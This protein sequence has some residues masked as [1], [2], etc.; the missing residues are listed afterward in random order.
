MIEMI[1]KK[2]LG[3]PAVVATSVRKSTWKERNMSRIN[4]AYDHT[5][6][7]YHFSNYHDWNISIYLGRFINVTIVINKRLETAVVGLFQKAMYR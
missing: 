2:G 7:K 5:E 6:N 1:H 4:F 3:D